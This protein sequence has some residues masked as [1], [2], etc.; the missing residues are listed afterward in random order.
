MIFQTAEKG[1]KKAS[2]KTFVPE[3]KFVP[4]CAGSC[5][6]VPQSSFLFTPPSVACPRIV[7]LL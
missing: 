4:F 1:G 3:Q 5:Q 6:F 2:P 7:T